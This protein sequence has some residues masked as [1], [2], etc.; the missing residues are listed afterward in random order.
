M[1]PAAVT[2]ERSGHGGEA[3]ARAFRV[4]YVAGKR[5]DFTI[6]EVALESVFH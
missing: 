3:S 1:Q 5:L 6:F 2:F 4:I